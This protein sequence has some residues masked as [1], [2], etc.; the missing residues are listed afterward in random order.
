[1]ATTANGA[2]TPPSLPPAPTSPSL[3]KRKRTET[4]AATLNGASSAAPAKL[5][6]RVPPP[7][8]AALE[9][10]LSVL[11]RYDFPTLLCAGCLH[12]RA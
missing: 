9:D 2:L 7:L 11:K 1:M 8:Q 12:L 3:A 4:D 6:D 10:I 5:A